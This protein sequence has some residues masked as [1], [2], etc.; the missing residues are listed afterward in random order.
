VQSSTNLTA[1]STLVCASFTLLASIPSCDLQPWLK[2]QY[3]NVVTVTDVQRIQLDLESHVRVHNMVKEV[4]FEPKSPF[5]EF[6]FV[7]FMLNYIIFSIVRK[8]QRAFSTLQ[9]A[10]RS[11][12]VNGRHLKVRTRPKSDIYF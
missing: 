6:V 7:K 12:V 5:R 9:T 8:G 2:A 4:G 1:Q 11:R 10:I 3:T